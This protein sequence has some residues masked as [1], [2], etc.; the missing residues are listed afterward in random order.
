MRRERSARSKQVR[1][2]VSAGISVEEQKKQQ[3]QAQNEGGVSSPGENRSMMVQRLLEAAANLPAFVHDLL[4]VQA[5]HVAGT[6]AAGFLIE[7]GGEGVN[8][9]PIAHIRPDNSDADTRQA[10]LQ[11]FAEIV[12]PCVDKGKDGA[13]EV[14]QGPEGGES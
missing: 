12:K 2:P 10:A 11:A 14:A 5:V 13:I 6:E 4:T 1:S 3:Q 8:L 9:R 7:R